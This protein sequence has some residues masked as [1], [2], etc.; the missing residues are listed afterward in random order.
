[1]VA[2]LTIVPKLQEYL[3]RLANVT[4][5]DSAFH[6]GLSPRAVLMW[7]RLSQARAFLDGRS[8][9][10]PDDIQAVAPPLFSIHITSSQQGSIRTVE[11][12]LAKVAVPTGIEHANAAVVKGAS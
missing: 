7:Q 4:R 9:V 5:D 3:V 11:D 2:S 6:H 1:M 10:T 8:F 12:I